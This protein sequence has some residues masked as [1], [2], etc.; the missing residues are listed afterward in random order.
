MVEPRHLT[1]DGRYRE[2]R[3]ACHFVVQAGRDAG[4]G[5]DDLWQ[6]ELACDEACTNIIEHAYG[7]EGAGE[8]DLTC[9][10]DGGDFVLS[11]RDSGS[12][13]EPRDVPLPSDSQPS[14]PTQLKSGGLGLFLMRQT[15]DDVSFTFAT[16]GNL[17]VMRKRLPEASD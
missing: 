9:H 17:L 12:A 6:I 14:D 2:I 15:M 4:L 10:V 13:F 16:E 11:I 1:I 3:R 7:R 8:I 5:E